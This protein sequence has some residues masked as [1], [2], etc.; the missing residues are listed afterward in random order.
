MDVARKPMAAVRKVALFDKEIR[1][2]LSSAAVEILFETADTLSEGERRGRGYFGSTMITLDLGRIEPQVREPCDVASARTVAELLALDERV[3]ERARVI[4]S[5]DAH[6]RA[7]ARLA[8][9]DC[10]IRARA[11]GTRVHLDVDVEGE[12]AGLANVAG[13]V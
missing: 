3:R 10:E 5:A 12:L 9:V 11:V 4:A 1:L 8:R 13:G 7:G 6:E 2:R